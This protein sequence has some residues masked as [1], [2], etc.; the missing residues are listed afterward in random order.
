MVSGSVRLVH[1]TVVAL[2]VSIVLSF[3][4]SAAAQPKAHS[5]RDEIPPAVRPD[6]DAAIGL[7]ETRD[8]AGALVQFQKVYELTKNPKVLQNVAS[9]ERAMLHYA[10]AAEL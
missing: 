1:A 5:L 9:C 10:R 6:W 4:F 7:Y 2:V 8:F 3:A